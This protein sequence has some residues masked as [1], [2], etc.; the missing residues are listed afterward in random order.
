MNI[1]IDSNFQFAVVSIKYEPCGGLCITLKSDVF[2]HNGSLRNK[3]TPDKWQKKAKKM[4]ICTGEE[5]SA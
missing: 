2:C 4:Y 1:R 3:N 5:Q